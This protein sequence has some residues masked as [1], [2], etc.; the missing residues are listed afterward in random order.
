MGG[1]AR[2][3]QAPRGAPPRAPRRQ[4]RPC[5][6]ISV[7]RRP[8]TQ[9][10]APR[11]FDPSLVRASCCPPPLAPHRWFPSRTRSSRAG[12]PAGKGV[13]A[14]E[15]EG[16]WERGERVGGG[17]ASWVRAGTVSPSQQA[18]VSDARARSDYCFLGATSNGEP[19]GHTRSRRERLGAAGGA[20]EGGGARAGT[21]GG[22]YAVGRGGRGRGEERLQKI[23][24]IGGR[25]TKVR[26]GLHG[27]VGVVPVAMFTGLANG[28]RRS[29]RCGSRRGRAPTCPSRRPAFPRDCEKGGGRGCARATYMLASP[30]TATKPAGSWSRP[31]ATRR[32]ICSPRDE[33]P[34][35]LGGALPPRV[36]WRRAHPRGRAQDVLVARGPSPDAPVRCKAILPLSAMHARGAA[37]LR[38]RAETMRLSG[39]S[40]ASSPTASPRPGVSRAFVR[41]PRRAT[42]SR[43]RPNPLAQMTTCHRLGPRL[44]SRLD[45]SRHPGHRPRGW[46]ARSVR[47]VDRVLSPL[48]SPLLSPVPRAPSAPFLAHPWPTAR[49]SEGRRRF[50][51]LRTISLAPCG[52]LG[53]PIDGSIRSA[54][55]RVVLPPL[56]AA[57]V[58]A[59]VGGRW[60]GGRGGGEVG[61]R[62]RGGGGTGGREPHAPHLRSHVRSSRPPHRA[63]VYSPPR[64]TRLRRAMSSRHRWVMSGCVVAFLVWPSFRGARLTRPCGWGPASRSPQAAVPTGRGQGGEGSG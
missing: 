26:S 31:N 16:G 53:G 51:P 44:A 60:K 21:G 62:G 52:L 64:L 47:V 1:R 45:A 37:G 2:A 38:T 61:G 12:T 63:A 15:G 19:G 35:G 8:W 6:R 22:R 50:D 49:P 56:L 4:V 23:K 17:N 42:F 55:S 54:P 40:T 34:G 27:S 57:A 10:A 32:W 14:T 11:R 39:R 20:R 5:A 7:A 25:G 46:S 33:R 9:A 58:V 30:G 43:S 18:I 24:G 41:A 13:R 48:L 3:S 36:G 28:W 29:H 59:P